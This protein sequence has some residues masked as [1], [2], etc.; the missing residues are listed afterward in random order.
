MQSAQLVMDP[1]AVLIPGWG[2]VMSRWG[3]CRDWPKYVT[4][5]RKERGLVI[6]LPGVEGGSLYSNAVRLGLEMAGVNLALVVR[7]WSGILPGWL[8]AF[9]ER[10]AR[11]R[12]ALLMRRIDAYRDEHPGRPV[13]IVGHSGGGCI[14]LFAAE[15]AGRDGR[16]LDGVVA[17]STAL[18]PKYD[19]SAALAGVRQGLVTV[20]SPSDWQLRALTSIGCNFDQTWSRTAGQTGFL[21]PPPESDGRLMQIGWEPA[22]RQEGHYGGHIGCTHPHWV[23]RHLG[24]VLRRWAGREEILQKMPE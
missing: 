17:M 12:A 14:S 7:N 5:Q 6:I 8:Y 1:L 10:A 24:P 23:A 4:P 15:Q 2:E 19:L 22:M 13:F 21:A 20:H 18:G 3:F 16:P 11:R 9:S